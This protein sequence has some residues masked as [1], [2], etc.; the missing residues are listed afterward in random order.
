MITGIAGF[1]W[2]RGYLLQLPRL[3]RVQAF[4]VFGLSLC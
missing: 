2:F 3:N 1:V 4:R